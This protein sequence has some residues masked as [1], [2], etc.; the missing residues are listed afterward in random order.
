MLI[1]KRL[2]WGEGSAELADG[3]AFAGEEIREV[4]D[5]LVCSPGLGFLAGVVAVEVGMT[6][7]RGVRP[8]R[9]SEKANDKRTP[10]PY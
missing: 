6:G 7:E 2:G 4:A 9:P 8:R 1:L 10:V 5:K 3:E